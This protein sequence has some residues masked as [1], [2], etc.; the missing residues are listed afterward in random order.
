MTLILD[1]YPID[2]RCEIVGEIMKHIQNGECFAMIGLAGAGKSNLINF[3]KEPEVIRHY[4][5]TELSDHTQL[6]LLNGRSEGA[7]R[8]KLY[9]AMLLRLQ[10]SGTSSE[11]K[12]DA[13]HTLRSTLKSIC[14]QQRIVFVIDEFE[15][16]I[17]RQPVDF[18]DEL[19][20]L[21]DDHRTS[22]NLLFVIVTH[23]LPHAIEEGAAFEKSKFFELFRDHYYPLRPYRP[24]DAEAMLDILVQRTKSPALTAEMRQALLAYSGGHSGLLYAL[25]YELT[26]QFQIGEPKVLLA[27]SQKLRDAADKI[28]IHL[29][30]DEQEALKA[31]VRGSTTDADTAQFL[32]KRGLVQKSSPTTLFCPLF[33][34]YVR[35]LL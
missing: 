31:L 21:R 25:F 14:K 2:Y 6:M 28:W 33:E 4:L 27:Q 5:P 13:L 15:Y 1:R 10:E 30:V 19:R 8:D 7:S 34:A 29:H 26:P 20:D 24:R 12:G 18:F 32:L 11:S 9:Q 17:Q 3:A 23:R 16:L 22:R 35:T